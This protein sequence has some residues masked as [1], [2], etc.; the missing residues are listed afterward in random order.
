MLRYVDYQVVADPDGE[1][2]WKA[3]CVSGDET[4]CGAESE[5]CGSD[6]APSD[7][8][9]EHCAQTGHN[10]FKRVFQDYALVRRKDL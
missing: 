2:T 5:E 3:R 8:M 7:W 10:R 4:E 6:E 9:A 1:R